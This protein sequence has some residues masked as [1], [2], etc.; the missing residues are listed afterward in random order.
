MTK[1]EITRLCAEAMGYVAAP[2]R[3]FLQPPTQHPESAVR[4]SPG[5]KADFW[6]DP[7]NNDAHA[8]GLLTVYP[9]TCKPAFEM[10]ESC[11]GDL[12]ALICHAVATHQLRS[13]QL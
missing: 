10:Y 13:K 9:T 4:V 8:F 1:I 5:A 12:R 3:L 7:R 6:Y 11:G 2:N